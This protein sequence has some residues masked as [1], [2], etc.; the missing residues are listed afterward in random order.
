MRT[1]F[2][3]AIALIVLTAGPAAAVSGYGEVVFQNRTS[4]AG[5]LYYGENYACYA[6]AG[7]ECHAMARPGRY[8]FIARYS[9]A[10]ADCGV[11]DVIEG[12]VTTCLVT[13]SSE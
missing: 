6:Q 13:E 7:L 11:L 5:N 10:A 4:E 8:Q 3:S 1:A 9:Q 12:E 2:A